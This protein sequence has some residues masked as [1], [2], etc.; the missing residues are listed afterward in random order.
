[1]SWFSRSAWRLASS[2]FGAS[3]SGSGRLALEHP[4]RALHLELER[5]ERRLQLVRGDR[6]ELVPRAHRLLR[7]LE[8]PHPLGLRRLLVG[9]VARDA[10]DPDHPPLVVPV[11]ALG[12]E[13]PA[14]LAVDRD[15]LLEGAGLGRGHQLPVELHHLRRALEVV[16]LAVVDPDHPLDRTPHPLGAGAVH[17]QVPAD[18]V[19]HV[20]RVAR[21][22][23]DRVEQLVALAERLLRALVGDR[24]RHH[25]RH[26]LE[27]EHLLL[28]EPARLAG[29]R[30]EHAVGLRGAADHHRDRAHHPEH[31]VAGRLPVAQ[32]AR[33][34][35]H[36]RGLAGEEREPELEVGVDGDRAL[37][38]GLQVPP[39]GRAEPELLPLAGDLPDVDHVDVERVGDERRGLGDEGEGLL[40]DE[41]AMSERG[42]RRVHP[43]LQPRGRDGGI[44]AGDPLDP[45]AGLALEHAERADEEDEEAGRPEERGHLTPQVRRRSPSPTRASTGTRRSPE[46][47]ATAAATFQPDAS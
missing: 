36:H 34:V 38:P 26:R 22:L 30:G 40:R 19:L 46:G 24:R 13:Q 29:V 16:D 3:F 27:E 20:D 1:M 14:R 2:S 17:H 8:Q 6:E 35:A 45:R 12:G 32:I 42:H 21:R 7:L 43:P 44:G 4:E 15:L 37:L 18:E 28:G 33:R 11:G 9:D 25:A 5:G 41:G 31:G 39:V 47:I 10:D 23:D